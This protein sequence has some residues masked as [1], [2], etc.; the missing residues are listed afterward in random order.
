MRRG[1]FFAAGLARG[2]AL[3]LGLFAA[4]V[5]AAADPVELRRERSEVAL[6]GHIE[7]LEDPDRRLAETDFSPQGATPGMAAL[8]GRLHA[9]GYSASAFWGRL[10]LVNTDP[11]RV[12]WMLVYRQAAVDRIEV[13]IAREG[14]A[15]QALAP[16]AAGRSRQVFGGMRYPIYGVSLAAGEQAALLIRIENTSPIRFPLALQEMS[17]FFMQDRIGRLWMGLA[18]M[19]PLVV[20]VYML[21]L[22]GAMRDHSLPLY[23]GFQLS[24]MIASAWIGGFLAE[25]LPMLP[26]R[27]LAGIGVGA[28]NLGLC[29][30]LLHA[31]AFLKLP[32]RHPRLARALLLC[33]PAFPL[34]AA[35]EFAH[36]AA[37]R[38]LTI[39]ATVGVVLFVFGASLQAWHRRLPLAGIY[40]LA[41]GSL[42][43]GVASLVASRLNLIDHGAVTQAQLAAGASSSLIFGFALAA[44]IRRREARTRTVMAQSWLLNAAH[45]D[46]RQP[47]QSL[48]IYLELL[49]GEAER[50][51]QVRALAGR[52]EAAYNGLAD[53]LDGML[54]LS[55]AATGRHEPQPRRL[56]VDDLLAPLVEEYRRL[57]AAV[58]LELRHV[59]CHAWIESDPRLLERIV[60]NLLANAVRYTQHGRILVGCRRRGGRLAIEVC[61][62]GPGIAARDQERMFARYTQGEEAQNRQAG[63]GLGLA[64]VRQLAERLGHEVRLHSVEGRGSRF[65][66]LAARL[67]G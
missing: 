12:D 1:P 38:P 49:R 7:V 53:F 50:P 11:Q 61:D 25:A 20:A 47:L 32:R 9:F 64:I 13:F 29:L 23:I 30:G 5:G 56:R 57:A 45:H 8:P 62:T 26:R 52:M 17:A 63:F 18:L 15:W 58:G 51:A 41:W 54:E 60:R 37:A 3:F 43:P 46:L 19:I 42:L 14:G 24:T 36:S 34:I 27:A 48:G 67:D 44:Q 39:V 22:W 10:A 33:A 28:F 31:R 6:F 21:F 59:P 4:A 66:V 16:Y 35:L 40:A 55:R 65:A 2:L